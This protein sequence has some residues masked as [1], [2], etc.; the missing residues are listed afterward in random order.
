[1]KYL[2]AMCVLLIGLGG[3]LASF[4]VTHPSYL[5]AK[6]LPDT[7]YAVYAYCPADYDKEVIRMDTA[8]EARQALTAL[9]KYISNPRTLCR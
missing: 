5:Y 3:G 9:N 8:Q 6:Q 4:T 2:I 7:R 1:M